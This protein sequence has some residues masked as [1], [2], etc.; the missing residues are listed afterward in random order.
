MVTTTHHASHPARCIL[1]EGFLDGRGDFLGDAGLV[2]H[3]RDDR[4]PAV[5]ME[6][7]GVAVLVQLHGGGGSRRLLDLQGLLGAAS[8]GVTS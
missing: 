3:A 6:R 4:A 1:S 2:D 5:D 7:G 8:V